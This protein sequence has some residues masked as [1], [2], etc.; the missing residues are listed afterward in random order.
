M[1]PLRRHLNRWVVMASSV[2]TVAEQ[3]KRNA[4]IAGFLGWTLDAFDFLIL[5]FVLTDV[6]ASFG[7]TRPDIAFTITLSLMMRPIGAIIFGAMADRLGRRRPM[8]LNVVFFAVI[9]VLCGLAPN[10]STFLVL[11]LLFGITLGGQWG[12]SASLALETVGIK[13]RGVI[14]GLLQEGYTFGN[15]LA[16]LVF[17]FVYPSY[18]W[19][20]LFFIGG[21]PALLVFFIQRRVKESPVWIEQQRTDW[22]SYLKLAFQHWRRFAFLVL[23]M[24]MVAGIAHGTQDLYPT[25]LKLRQYTPQQIAD[26]TMISMIG[27]CV[28]G[29]LIGVV[30]DRWGRRK[31]MVLASLC[32]LLVVPFWV[33]APSVALIATAAFVMQ[34]FVQGTAGVVPAHFNEL[35]PGHLRGLFPGV[36]Y[37][38]GVL[39]SSGIIYF[40]SVLGEY[41]SYEQS[42]GIFAAVMFLAGIIVFALGPENKGVSFRKGGEDLALDTP[43][44]GGTVPVL[45]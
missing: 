11:R 38:L 27:A 2:A 12:V 18:G 22:S 34:L 33:L 39:C 1:A 13:R 10:Y 40:E 19:R 41:V 5:T 21:L 7:K 28:G 44:L 25:M 6:A 23:L 15:L 29:L 20:P 8:M 30:S 42:M 31:A 24:T 4:V 32:G 17:R 43:V 26:V 3:D 45:N 35:T 37:Q 9:S 16:A 36:A 14:S